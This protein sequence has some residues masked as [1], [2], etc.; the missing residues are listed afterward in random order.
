VRGP[1]RRSTVAAMT[2]VHELSDEQLRAELERTRAAYG[3]YVRDV[4]EHPDHSARELDDEAR[5]H[6]DVR[7]EIDRRTG[8]YHHD[9]VRSAERGDQADTAHPPA[10]RQGDEDLG[11]RLDPGDIEPYA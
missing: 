10:G 5:R 8:G 1:G 3:E 11:E 9:D 4:G 2:S 7:E 6:L